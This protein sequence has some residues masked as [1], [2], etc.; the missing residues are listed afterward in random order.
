[1]RT[2][3][4]DLRCYSPG[5]VHKDAR[6]LAL[7]LSDD[8]RLSLLRIAANVRVQ[9][10][11]AEEVQLVLHARPTHTL[12]GAEH[13][14]VAVAVRA[15]EDGHVLHK[16]QQRDV[17]LLEHV[18]ALDRVLDR[19]RVRRRHDDRA[20][21]H[22]LLRDAE[23]RVA[24]ARGQVEHE[25]VEAAPVDLVQELLQ[26]LHDHHAAPHHWRLLPDEVA[27]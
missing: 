16:P 6:Q 24:R 21:Q 12:A 22:D 1:M 7:W 2:S 18:D 5:D 20:V 3:Q 4:S 14:R 11:V 25:H 26:R 15:A 8:R 17:D 9:G 27:H 13:V 23:L 10:H 19:Q